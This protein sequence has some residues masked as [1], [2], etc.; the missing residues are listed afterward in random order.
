MQPSKNQVN[1]FYFIYL[2]N[3]QTK[4]NILFSV[5]HHT[6]YRISNMLFHPE[7]VKKYI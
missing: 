3:T 6:D 5:I 2:N 7:E 4:M 1:L